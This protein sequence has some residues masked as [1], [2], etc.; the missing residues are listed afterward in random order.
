MSELH[1][2][3]QAPATP[4]EKECSLDA[5]LMCWWISMRRYYRDFDRGSVNRYSGVVIV[6][7]A[8]TLA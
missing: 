7:S 1:E 8:S 5:K 2:K 3:V 6:P 4:A